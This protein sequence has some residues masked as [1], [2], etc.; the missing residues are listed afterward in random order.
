[1]H[2][3]LFSATTK[4]IRRVFSAFFV[5]SYFV[6]CHIIRKASEH[7]T[8]KNKVSVYK[9]YVDSEKYQRKQTAI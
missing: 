3:K 8:V 6:L 5:I 1:M 4:S 9:V 2:Q 7:D